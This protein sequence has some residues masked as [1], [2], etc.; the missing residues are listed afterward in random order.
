MGR[1]FG[2]DTA[3]D[4]VLQ[5]TLELGGFNVHAVEDAGAA[6]LL[7]QRGGGHVEAERGLWPCGYQK[8]AAATMATLF[9]AGDMFPPKLLI[10][11]F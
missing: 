3:E 11:A 6:W 7:G 1:M 10:V 4:L 2:R 9:W 8:P 5:R